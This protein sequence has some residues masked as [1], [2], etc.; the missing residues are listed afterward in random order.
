M[1]GV[2]GRWFIVLFKYN[3]IRWSM[4]MSVWW[5][6]CQQSVFQRDH[7]EKRLSEFYPQDGG[8]SQL[9][10]K[11]RHCHPMYIWNASAADA[12][13]RA[14]LPRLDFG[15]VEGKGWEKGKTKTRWRQGMRVMGPDEL[16]W[17]KID[18][19]S[20]TYSTSGCAIMLDGSV[21]EWLACWTQAQ[22]GSNRAVATLS[23]N[24]LRQTVH[25]HR[26]SVH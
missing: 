11:L 8:D 21:A 5:L 18:A 25:T 12:R 23:G 1:H 14:A 13:L 26:A 7:S 17:E 3:S 22:K 16:V 24:S 9:A 20:M 4:K 6:A 15:D 19:L 2:N 10:S